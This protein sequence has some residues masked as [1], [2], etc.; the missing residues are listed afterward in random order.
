M[1]LYLTSEQGNRVVLWW[2]FHDFLQKNYLSYRSQCMNPQK[3][4][5]SISYKYYN[6][7]QRAVFAFKKLILTGEKPSH[8]H[9]ICLSESIEKY[10]IFSFKFF[11]AL[12]ILLFSGP[13]IKTAQRQSDHVIFGCSFTLC[14]WSSFKL[15]FYIPC[16]SKT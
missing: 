4:C 10:S 1:P 3:T 6:H 15:I 8:L 12:N 16:I 14:F 13:S 11:P 5:L 2:K 7:A 9:T